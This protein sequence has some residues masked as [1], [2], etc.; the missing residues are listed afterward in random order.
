MAIKAN[1]LG[2]AIRTKEDVYDIV[3]EIAINF[4]CEFGHLPK[5]LYVTLWF[6]A[7]PNLCL[8]W[9]DKK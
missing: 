7:Y 3:L 5:V 2:I 1:K 4:K 9:F 6:I 8:Y